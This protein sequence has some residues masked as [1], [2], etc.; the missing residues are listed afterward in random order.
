MHELIDKREHSR[1]IDLWVDSVKENVQNLKLQQHT[2]N[3]RGKQIDFWQTLNGFNFFFLCFV[4]NFSDLIYPNSIW[5]VMFK[6]KVCFALSSIV[7]VSKGVEYPLYF[8]DLDNK[9]RFHW[10]IEWTKKTKT[11]IKIEFVIQLVRSSEIYSIIFHSK[12]GYR[13]K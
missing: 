3:Q 12:A 9:E 1:N 7:F 8:G 11:K 5:N 13:F 10:M 6:S 2:W 4:R